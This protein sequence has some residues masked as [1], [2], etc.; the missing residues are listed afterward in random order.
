[1]WVDGYS[2]GLPS[3]LGMSKGNLV[4]MVSHPGGEGWGHFST[5][6]DQVSLMSPIKEMT[7]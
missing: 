7:C 6:I 5:M 2:L 1:M 3:N 4:G